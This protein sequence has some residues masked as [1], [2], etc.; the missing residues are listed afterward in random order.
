MRNSKNLHLT[1]SKD[2]DVDSGADSGLAVQEAKPRLKK[3]PMYKV[4]LLNDDY[5]P[6][7][8]VVHVLESF[9]NMDREKATHV[10]LTVHTKGKAVCGVYSRDVAETKAMQVNQFARQNE[11]PLLCEIEAC[12]DGDSD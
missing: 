6:M 3:P 1:L 2:D 4:V 7:E 9:F 11:H 5:T 8:F 12:D 10:M